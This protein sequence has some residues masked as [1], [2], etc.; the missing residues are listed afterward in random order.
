PHLRDFHGVIHDVE[1][2]LVLA[3]KM[4]VEPAFAELERRGNI[5]HGSGV[6]PLLAEE[7]GGG[8]QDFLAGVG[9]SFARHS[10]N[11]VNTS[12]P[13]CQTFPKWPRFP[14]TSQLSEFRIRASEE[15][16]LTARASVD[17]VRICG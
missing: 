13:D 10:R 16:E 11:M 15:C 2:N 8:T 9:N 12:R 3:A 6:V 7:A 4:M 1:E 14:A 5:V 17:N